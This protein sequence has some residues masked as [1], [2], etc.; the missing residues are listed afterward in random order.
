MY[1]DEAEIYVES[2]RGGDGI[3]HFHREKYKPRGGPDGGDG[4]RGGDVILEV[5]P[6]INTLFDF[7][8]KSR[9]I[10]DSGKNGGPNNMSGKSAKDLVVM[11][12]PGTLVYDADSGDLLG[13]LVEEG[14]QLIVAKGG[15]G[16]RGNQHYATS[17][18][19]T[20]RMAEKGVPEE[21][22]T[23][24]LELKMIADIGIVGV[25]NAGKSSLLSVVSNAKPKIGNYPF[26]TLSPNLGV[27]K[28]D[29]DTILVLADIPGLIEGAHEGVGLGFSFLRHI[30]R[31]KVLIHVLDGLSE[32]PLSDFSQINSEMAL[33]D[34]KIKIKPQIVAF[35]KMDLPSV[36]ARY[37][38]IKQAIKGLGF[39]IFPISTVTH[40]NVDQLM[41]RTSEL[42]REAPEP[43]PVEVM[44]VYRASED[45]KAFTVEEVEDGWQVHGEAIERA[46]A[47]TYWEHRESVR[48]F[49]RL[50]ENIGVEEALR[51]AGVEEGD[52]VYVGEYTLEWQD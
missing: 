47:M 7:R 23:L 6:H 43:E 11:V 48:R 22:R 3:V 17:R 40:E 50:M 21:S 9:F 32:D 31:T 20:P 24:R 30:Q 42:V 27:A 28:L 51:E 16:G 46:A 10:A 14:Q 41:W 49:Q 12:P 33:F 36:Q 8:H 45:P 5:S 39:E 52:T 44:P 2:G 19:Q 13:D 37:P 34:E 26:T 1:L 15:R 25:P 4:G 29:V 35:N 38:E 18:N